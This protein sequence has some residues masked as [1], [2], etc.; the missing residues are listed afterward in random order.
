MSSAGLRSAQ[1]AI[2]GARAA[3]ER[4]DDG[5]HPEDN[6]AD[7]LEAWDG[8]QAALRALSGE[9]T[10]AGHALI[11]ESR[12][13]NFLSLDQAHALV[14]FSAV[15]DRARDPAYQPTAA[16]LAAARG[17]FQLL[18]A[19]MNRAPAAD[20]QAPPPPSQVLL[21]EQQPYVPPPKSTSSNYLARG[22]VGVSVLLVVV[23]IVYYMMQ[24]RARAGS[25]RRAIA[26]YTAGDRVTAK[27]EFALAAE[28]NP[29]S[30]E[31]HVYLGRIAREEGDAATAAR[32]L[33]A[34]VTLEPENAVALREMGSHLLA[35]GNLDLARRFYVRAVTQ[36]PEDR[37]ALGYLACTLARLGRIP[38]AQRFLQRAGPGEWSNC[39]MAVPPPGAPP[40]Q[41]QIPR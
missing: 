7:L 29:R 14:E 40:V 24:Y 12:H 26:A 17:G 10:L 35:L 28:R 8:T 13:R 20:K 33:N 37:L 25:M 38:E 9:N 21:D 4:L 6:A 27:R 32:E 16:D 39:V 3:I 23:A 2:D 11:R 22:I 41:G 5:R 15:A 34:A 30:A 31:P 19:A 36:A 18:E 1:A